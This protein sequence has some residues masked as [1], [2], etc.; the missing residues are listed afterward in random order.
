MNQVAGIDVGKRQLDAFVAEQGSRRFANTPAGIGQLVGWLGDNIEQVVLEPT[1][2]YERLVCE[3]LRAAGL[4]VHLAHT[5]KV[6]GFARAQGCLAKTDRIDAQVL[7][8]YGQAFR[9]PATA[10]LE[11]ARQTL[12][13]LLR[14]REQL[15]RQRVEERNRLE[16]AGIERESIDRHID[17]LSQ[18]IGQ[19]ERGYRQQLA[20]TSSLKQPADLYQS[21]AG[22]GQLTAATL[23]AELPELG[24]LSGAALTAL[25]GL[26]PW[27]NDSGQRN[28][29]RSIRGGRARV[30]RALY[31]A[32]L[33]GIT[34]NPCLGKFY[35]GLKK[36]GKPSKVAL[37]A[38]MRKLLLQLNA[39]AK[40]GTPWQPK[41]PVQSPCVLT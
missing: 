28:G 8:E 11:P 10:A 20:Q 12:Q 35:R 32:A 7:S 22:V 16:H 24:H 6:R 39:I 4:S 23:V 31:M 25:V 14:R 5:Q 30:R 19:L 26:A 18:E 17:W 2:G 40:R 27:S 13:S 38:M 1:G 15:V 37:V 33:A 21:I 34:Y 9:L 29:Y 41:V 36:R 3:L